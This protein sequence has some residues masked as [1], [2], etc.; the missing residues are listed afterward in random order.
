MKKILCLALLAGIIMITSSCITT[1]TTYL[2]KGN[3]YFDE[4]NWTQAIVEYNK[5]IEMDPEMVEAYNNRGSAYIELGEFEKAIADYTKS[6]EID[7]TNIILYYDRSMAYNH[8]GEWD[9]AIDDCNRVFELGLYNHFVYYNRGVANKGKGDYEAALAD[10]EEAKRRTPNEEFHQL[11][12][13]QINE[14]KAVMDLEKT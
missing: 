11:A 6:I 8:T 4:E 14:I 1:A 9:K 10:F 13:R 3:K 7:P 12:D 5:A 2:N